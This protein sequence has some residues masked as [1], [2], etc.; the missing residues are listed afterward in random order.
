MSMKVKMICT[1]LAGLTATAS[2]ADRLPSGPTYKEVLVATVQ[3]AAKP[4][5]SGRT[6]TCREARPRR[7]RRS[8][9]SSTATAARAT[10]PTARARMNSRSR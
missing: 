2:A 5:R 6:S 10:S 4:L 9:S 3:D 8:C 1:L 7:R